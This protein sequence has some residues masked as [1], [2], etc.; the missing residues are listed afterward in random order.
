[1]PE[2][3]LRLR[4][5]QKSKKGKNM[6]KGKKEPGPKEKIEDRGGFV[7]RRGR[8]GGGDKFTVKNKDK[9]KPPVV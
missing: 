6:E 4:S 1:V 5:Q 7:G 2:C 8:R 9:N 3:G